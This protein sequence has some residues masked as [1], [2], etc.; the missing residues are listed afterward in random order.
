[1][2]FNLEIERKRFEDIINAPREFDNPKDEE[3]FYQDAVCDYI[4]RISYIIRK[5]KKDEVTK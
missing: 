4:L 1:M 2:Y 5:V 3:A